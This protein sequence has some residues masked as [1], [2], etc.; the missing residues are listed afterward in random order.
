MALSG[1][2]IDRGVGLSP[3]GRTLAPERRDRVEYAKKRGH[4]TLLQGGLAVGD[5]IEIDPKYAGYSEPASRGVDPEDGLT[6]EE[7]ALNPHDIAAAN[8]WVVRDAS[9]KVIEQESGEKIYFD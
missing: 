5:L 7:W 4:L 3:D 6:F 8:E 1:H 9:G 2:S